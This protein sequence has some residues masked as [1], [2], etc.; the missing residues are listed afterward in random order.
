MTAAVLSLE[1]SPALRAGDAGEPIPLAAQTMHKVMIDTELTATIGAQPC[2]RAR[3]RTNWSRELPTPWCS[4]RLSQAAAMPC[5]VVPMPTTST[6]HPPCEEAVAVAAIDA[7]ACV[8]PL[9]P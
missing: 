6:Q 1:R 3:S 4:A 5:R 8:H 9:Y 2:E 7:G